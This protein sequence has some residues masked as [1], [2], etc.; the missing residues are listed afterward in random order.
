MRKLLGVGFPGE[1][2]R[3]ETLLGE[4]QV[5]VAPKELAAVVSEVRASCARFGTMPLGDR[6][7]RLIVPADGLAA[8]RSTPPTLDELKQRVRAIAGTDFGAHSPR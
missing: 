2:A 4:V 8:D 7:Y 5:A 3:T 1:P 6:V